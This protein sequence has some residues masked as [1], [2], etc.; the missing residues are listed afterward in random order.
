VLARG[1]NRPSRRDL[2]VTLPFALLALW[3]QRNIAV[4][5]LVA[6]PVMAR[7]V[8]TNT[9]RPDA[10]SMVNSV[11]AGLLAAMVALFFVQA[12]TVPNFDTRAYPVRA[13]HYA[14]T[15]GLLGRHLLV[16]DGTGGYVILK[17]WPRQGVFVDD[18]FDMY[19]LPILHDFLALTAGSPRWRAIL[20]RRGLDVVVWDRSAPLGVYLSG[21][22]DWEHAFRSKAAD[23]FVRR[24]T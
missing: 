20:D 18:R 8:A 9:D 2:V 21:D 10:P 22:P 24:G 19:P 7:A 6:L 3:A 14:E 16:D 1:R 12:G 17:Y 11:F 4:A 13:L 23:V 5:P 15:H